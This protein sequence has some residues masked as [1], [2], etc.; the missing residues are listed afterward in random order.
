MRFPCYLQQFGAG[1]CHFKGIIS[2][3]QLFTLHGILQLGFLWELFR[4]VLGF[5]SVELV[6][7]W[8]WGW[9]RFLLMVDFKVC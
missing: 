1:S 6:K 3:L 4:V 7:G 2:V 9:F 5:N 8:S